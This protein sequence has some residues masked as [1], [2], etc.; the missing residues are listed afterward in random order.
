MRERLYNLLIPPFRKKIKFKEDEWFFVMHIPKTAGTTLR[1][2]LY[3]HTRSEDIY[4]SYDTLQN[5]QNGK[6]KPGKDFIAEGMQELFPSK[7]HLLMG[8]L[9]Y[10]FQKHFAIK[11]KV[12]SFLRDPLQRTISNILHLKRK[13]PRFSAMSPEE[14]FID[15]RT[16]LENMQ[17]RLFGYHKRRDN[18]NQALENLDKS[19]FIGITE[20]FEESIE[21]L[22]QIF[23]WPLVARKP[24]N[25]TIKSTESEISPLFKE[26]LLEGLK[27]DYI[28]YH[29]AIK[30]F[31]AKQSA[32]F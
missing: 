9:P 4:P 27:K 16:G 3:N 5:K 22:N 24:M 7:F 23:N 12:I 11:P 18:F 26:Q 8:H 29:R 1:Y 10:Q 14:I 2:T 19:A 21:L 15:R 30:N 20:R 25:K 6:Y 13:N 17:C 28:L 32:L 31:E